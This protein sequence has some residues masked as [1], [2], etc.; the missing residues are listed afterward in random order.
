MIIELIP[1]PQLKINTYIYIYVY[2]EFFLLFSLIDNLKKFK[3]IL[4]LLKQA[5]H[6]VYVI[7][8]INLGSLYITKW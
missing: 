4:K 1:Q 3:L 2:M 5:S 8:N 6:L 7:S